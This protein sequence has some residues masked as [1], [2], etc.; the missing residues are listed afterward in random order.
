M[1]TDIDA[2]SAGSAMGTWQRESVAVLFFASLGAG[3][4]ASL[5]SSRYFGSP[6]ALVQGTTAGTPL[7]AVRGA[8]PAISELRRI[9]GLTWDQLARLFGLSRRSLHYWASGGALTAANEEHLQRLLA[10]VRK[11][12]RGTASENRAALLAVA[13]DEAPLDL[14]AQ[15]QYDRA[16][17]LLGEGSLGR[18]VT[19]GLS[20]EVLQ[21]RRPSPPDA[22]VTDIEDTVQVKPGR[23]LASKPIR[24]SRRK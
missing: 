3:T 12:D 14:L 15:G 16:V 9:S 20:D 2:T 17:T 5:P 6:P 4:T 22:F 1:R 23:L 19:P 8:G 7:A 24:T 18:F 21:T 13:E 11:I 10:V